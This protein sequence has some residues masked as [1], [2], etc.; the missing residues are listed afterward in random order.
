MSLS[1]RIGR[2]TRVDVLAMRR[3]SHGFDWLTKDILLGAS[4]LPTRLYEKLSCRDHQFAPQCSQ[5]TT[6]IELCWRRFASMSSFNLSGTFNVFKLLFNPSLCL[7]HATVSSFNQIPLPISKAFSHNKQNPNPDIR[8]VV[9]DKDNCFAV[10]HEN[11]V[12]SDYKV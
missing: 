4:T 11:V 8:A 12:Y 7:P 9:L 5:V 6:L 2:S 3:A 1:P 10:P